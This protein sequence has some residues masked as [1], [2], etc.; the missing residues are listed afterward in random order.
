MPT[1]SE[2]VRYF[3]KVV[4][5]ATDRAIKGVPL[6]ARFTP[7]TL[8]S[9]YGFGT[10]PTAQQSGFMVNLLFAL[11]AE[12]ADMFVCRTACRGRDAYRSEADAHLRPMECERHDCWAFHVA[13]R[14]ALPALSELVGRHWR[15][16]GGHWLAGEYPVGMQMRRSVALALPRPDERP[17]RARARLFGLTPMVALTYDDELLDIFVK[18]PIAFVQQAL[19]RASAMN[20]VGVVRDE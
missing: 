9:V 18:S 1:D 8:L 20:S 17:E 5:S 7:F 11:I 6:A 14:A 19:A 10:A 3:L 13:A 2:K 4:E 15:T 12:P 16:R